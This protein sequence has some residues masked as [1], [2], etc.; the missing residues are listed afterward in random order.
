MIF[1]YLMRLTIAK[2]NI[3]SANSKL[4]KLFNQ[5]ADKFSNFLLKTFLSQFASFSLSM[6]PLI[7]IRKF[8]IAP[9]FSLN[10][11]FQ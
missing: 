1:C 6:E 8:N 2:L 7:I 4:Y 3:W 5:T 10:N 9:A 11:N